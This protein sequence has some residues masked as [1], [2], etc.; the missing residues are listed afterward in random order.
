MRKRNGFVQSN[1]KQ[2]LKKI[3]LLA[4]ISFLCHF[5]WV[6]SIFI[7]PFFYISIYIVNLLPCVLEKFTLCITRLEKGA[8][9]SQVMQATLDQAIQVHTLARVIVPL[10]CA[11]VRLTVPL[12]TLW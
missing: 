8:V 5:L 4:P 1:Q 3:D 6:H 12:S 2:D 11:L 7:S 9:T 10:F